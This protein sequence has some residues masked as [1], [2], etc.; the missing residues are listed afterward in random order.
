MRHLGLYNLLY[1]SVFLVVLILIGSSQAF[2]D[3]IELTPEEDTYVYQRKPS[4]SFGSN[5]YVR[6]RASN[7]RQRDGLIRF[8]FL[9]IPA[10]TTID[11][12]TLSV[13]VNR[14]WG[15]RNVLSVKEA[16][17]NWTESTTWNSRPPSSS[18]VEDSV[19]INKTGIYYTLDITGL[20]Q[21]WVDGVVDNNGLYIVT[22]RGV[23]IFNSSENGSNR[24]VLEVTYTGGLQTGITEPDPAPVPEPQPTPKPTPAPTPKPEPTPEPTP[25]PTPAPTPKPEPT[26]EPTPAPTPAPTPKP[27]PTPEPT[28]APVPAPGDTGVS[29]APL[30]PSNK[31][32]IV[33]AEDGSG[34]FSSIQSA[35]DSSQPGDTIQVKDG[36]YVERVNFN[37]S[38]TRQEPITLQNYP[39]HAPVIDPGGGAYPLECCPP[40]GTPRVEFNAEWIILE[41]FEIRY[42]WEGIKMYK[43][44]S[45]IR[46]NWIHNNRLQGIFIVSTGDVF[47]EGNVIE[48]N[49]TDPGA[50]I[51]DGVEG[52]SPRHCHGVYMSDWF[53]E[54]SRNVTIRSNIVRNHGGTAVQ[55]NGL[56]CSSVMENNLLENNL[57]EN[58]SWGIAMFYQ[59]TGS[60]IRNNTFVMESYP[61]TNDTIHPFI[62]IYGSERNVIRN[63]IFRS[64]RSDVYG[65]YVQ[66][67]RSSANDYD[68]NLWDISSEWWKWKGSWRD[69]FS[70]NYRS[71]TG[72][73]DNSLCCDVD[74]GFRSMSA[75]DYHIKESSSARDMGDN[76]ICALRDFDDEK[77][78]DD[79]VCDVGMDEL[80]NN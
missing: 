15:F 36:V 80:L 19:K 60:V 77:R 33:V 22:N 63:N 38:G 61:N 71:Q 74:P 1:G 45:T 34:D 11:S 51:N 75:G 29:D 79:A 54:G 65:I 66:D 72:W 43:G 58:N 24:P 68:F 57:F 42:G 18:Q 12:A 59:V 37:R 39:N 46:N 14:K 32:V 67:E 53:C 76:E 16:L 10:G 21:D 25:A 64:S 13:Y 56:G 5:S 8:D 55:W 50:C 20:V 28:P 30:S 4:S 6:L 47:V 23:V 49:G 27:E 31:R 7:N 69:G 44:H 40:G 73:G 2:A 9:E 70:N 52:E 35:L 17:D 62:A 41:G 3:V 26:P 78:T 48:Y